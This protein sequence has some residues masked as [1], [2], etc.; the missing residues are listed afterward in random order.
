MAA[1][2]IRITGL[3]TEIRCV[4]AVEVTNR[5]VIYVIKCKLTFDMSHGSQGWLFRFLDGMETA[6]QLHTYIYYEGGSS[7]DWIV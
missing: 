6:P 5:S 2:L 3:I 4:V 1:C 7:R